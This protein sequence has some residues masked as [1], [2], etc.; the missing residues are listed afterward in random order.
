MRRI[1]INKHSSTILLGLLTIVPI[2]AQQK[3]DEKFNV[4]EDVVINLNTSHTNV[5]FESWSKDVVAVEAFIEGD[6]LTKEQLD[7]IHN[8]WQV[9]A[10]GNS[11]D[12]SIT[13]NTQRIVR[14]PN[15][16]TVNLQ[17]NLQELQMLGPMITGL[18]EPLLQNIAQN[19][20][21]KKMQENIGGLHFDYAAYQNDSEKYMKKWEANLKEKF[22]DDFEVAMQA[23]GARMEK[24]AARM[25]QNLEA[26]MQSWTQQFER[27]M[28]QW[29]QQ[30]ERQ[31]DTWASQN[32]VAANTGNGA[33]NKAPY[34]YEVKDPNRTKSKSKARKMLKVR[35]PKNAQLKLNIRHGEVTLA[36]Y[37]TNLR[38]SLSHTKLAA[39]TI[40]GKATKIKASYSPVSVKNWNKGILIV[41]YVKNCRIENAKDIRLKTNSSN[42]YIQ[43]L[44]ANGLISGNFGS[45]TIANMNSDFSS[46]NLNLQNSDLKLILPKA[47]FNFT[48]LGARNLIQLPKTLEVQ[49]MRNFG[50][51]SIT[52]FHKTRNTDKA[53]T[54]N[55][56][57][58]DL[59]LQ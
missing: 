4:Q 45:I 39:N 51:E 58:S 13:S 1:R 32:V 29:G 6:D 38:A 25:G 31:M 52:G 23:W 19:P 43:N 53:I 57:Y 59:Q 41:D 24:D 21:P 56:E 35:I 10:T 48:Y 7:H 18:L 47:G 49:R 54:I 42:V 28:Q 12:I 36:D 55:A 27:D 16:V 15:A 5:V 20:I 2:V 34:I 8:N 14:T 33:H 30:F 3:L 26:Q 11:N 37:A 44:N 22:G 40:D 46:L 9:T 50:T 17:G